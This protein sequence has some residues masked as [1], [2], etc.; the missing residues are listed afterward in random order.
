[1]NNMSFSFGVIIFSQIFIQK[2]GGSKHFV[3]WG[4]TSILGSGVNSENDGVLIGY[5]YV[6]GI[7]K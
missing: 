4:V 2:I 6:A 7:L 5:G 3:S 1:M